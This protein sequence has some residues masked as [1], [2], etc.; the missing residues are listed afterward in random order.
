MTSLRFR[1]GEFAIARPYRT[2]SVIIPTFNRAHQLHHAIDSALGQTYAPDE[3][4]IVD[5]G[6]TDDTASVAARYG[7][8]VRYVVQENA[9]VSSARNHGAALASSDL[10]AFLDSD[11]MWQPRKLAVQVAALNA[12]PAAGW[13]ISG[14]DVIGLDNEKITGKHGWSSVF[15]VFDEARMQPREFFEAHFAEV[16]A[17]EGDNRHSVYEGDAWSPLFLGNFVLPSS[18]LISRNLF[19][20]VGG[21]DPA[22]RLAEETEFFHRLAAAAR[23]VVVPDALVGYRVSDSGS[24]TSPA[25]TVKLIDNALASLDKARALRDARGPTEAYY[26][27]GR[28]AL[29]RNRAYAELSM[30]DGRNARKAIREAWSSGA[31]WD[32]RSLAIY[33][34]S[35]VPAPALEMMHRLK[36]RAMGAERDTRKARNNVA[37]LIS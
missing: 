12:A 35:L 27:R 28:Q 23:L 6:S 18:A 20:R 4:I 31:P 17:E 5:D 33:G 29:L 3:I 32:R 24:L 19:T 10:V 36:K 22:L 37:A 21:F 9:G 16:T 15:K 34:L 14:C 1:T 7:D 30:K 8:K 2:V 11:D 26:K 25:N 13:C